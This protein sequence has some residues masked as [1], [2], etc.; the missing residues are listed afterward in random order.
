VNH[1]NIAAIDGVEANALII[2]FVDGDDLSAMIA[3]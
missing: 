3:Q 1:P 2:E